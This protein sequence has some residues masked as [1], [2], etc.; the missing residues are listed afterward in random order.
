[1]LSGGNSVY[2]CPHPAAQKASL[3][4]IRVVNDAIVKAGGP[5]NLVV[6]I[7]KV[8]LQSVEYACKHKYVNMVSATGGPAVGK[9]AL[10]SGKKAAVAGPGNP[11]V[12][13]DETA[14]IEKAAKDIISGAT[15]DN[16]ILC[17][18][19]KEI[20]A[21]N[22]IADRLLYELDKNNAY[23]LNAEESQKVTSLVVVDGHINK[24]YI[25]KNASVILKAAGINVSDDVMAGIIDVPFDHPLVGLEQMMPI[26]PLVRAKDFDEA[27]DYSIKAEHGFGHT[28]MIHSKD[29]DRITR[30]G[31]EMKVILM[32]ANAPSGASLNVGGEG[33]YTHTIA[34]TGEGVCTPVD[35]TREHRFIIGN[36]LRFV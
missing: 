7:D 2:I 33:Q 5:E 11:P 34:D 4:T 8:D 15:F 24:G 30:F 22:S 9:I 36:S 14:D 29:V 35:F 12:L 10:A 21:V 26:I 18:A 23:I 1:M 17:I 16:N 20:F 27:L 31:R 19:E 6:A 3:E 13:V 32:V 25:G 28:A